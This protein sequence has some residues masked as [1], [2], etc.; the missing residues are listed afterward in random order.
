MLSHSC[1]LYLVSPVGLANGVL[2]LD[3]FCGL[4]AEALDSGPVEAFLLRTGGGE[5]RLDDAMLE[6]QIETLL[7]PLHQRGVPLVLEQRVDLVAR[8]GCDGVH[9]PASRRQVAAVRQTLGAAAI[10]GAAAGGSRHAAMEAAEAGADYVTFGLFDP[11]PRPPEEAL[12]TWWQELMELPVVAMGG[13]TLENARRLAEAG[14]DFLALRN[15][16]WNHEQGP[17]A[18]LDAFRALLR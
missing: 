14:A 16:V 6:R 12:L 10:L 3:R 2:A 8:L 13:I 1:G 15:A 5:G 9:L 18:A 7:A 11:E 4:L 17:A